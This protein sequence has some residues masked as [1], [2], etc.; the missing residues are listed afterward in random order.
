MTEPTWELVYKDQSQERVLFKDINFKL[1]DTI[2]SIR[3][4]WNGLVCTSS[5]SQK[6]I[7]L[8]WL[9]EKNIIAL[10]CENARSLFYAKRNRL[11][12]KEK[13]SSLRTETFVIGLLVSENKRHYIE[14]ANEG[15]LAQIREELV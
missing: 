2:D 4:R 7:F 1:D 13:G 15:L 5:L 12:L 8:S 10:P 6:C 3:L 9:G 14:V 11:I